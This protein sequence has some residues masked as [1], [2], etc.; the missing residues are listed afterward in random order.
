MKDEKFNKLRDI[1]FESD[2]MQLG[3]VE[4]KLID[5]YDAEIELILANQENMNKDRE[6]VIE[7]IE[8]V[9]DEMFDTW[10]ELD[11]GFIDNVAEV[12]L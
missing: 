11:A 6:G 2:P 7:L 4:N 12:L 9:I 1:F 10:I 5:E 3:V 8:F